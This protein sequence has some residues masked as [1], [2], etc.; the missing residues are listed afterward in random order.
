[1][2]GSKGGLE[3]LRTDL[4]TNGGLGAH[5]QYFPFVKAFMT[6]IGPMAP[7]LCH[8]N[9]TFSTY[10]SRVI[11]FPLRQLLKGDHTLQHQAFLL[12]REG[13]LCT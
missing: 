12:V 3:G 2:H 8:P 11:E 6:E 1:M 5:L 9:S 10:W 4:E 13:S 7:T